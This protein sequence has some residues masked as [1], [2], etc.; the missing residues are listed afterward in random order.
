MKRHAL[1]V[2]SALI[3][4]M[5]CSAV[6]ARASQ[7]AGPLAGPAPADSAPAV[8]AQQ[9]PDQEKASSS[10]AKDSKASVQNSPASGA[11]ITVPSGTRI[12]LVLH[13]AIST[14]SA[15]PGDP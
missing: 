3:F 14:R 8:K 9:S 12:P 4:A 7:Q 15:R 1:L 2:G 11:A 5:M 10:A 6:V 13:N